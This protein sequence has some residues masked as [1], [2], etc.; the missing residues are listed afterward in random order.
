MSLSFAPTTKAANVEQ[1]SQRNPSRTVS[2]VACTHEINFICQSALLLMAPTQVNPTNVHMLKQ[3][4]PFESVLL[5][6]IF[7]L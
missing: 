7:F 6:K 5:M 1:K 3:L 2:R 4:N